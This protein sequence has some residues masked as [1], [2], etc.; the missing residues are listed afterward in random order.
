MLSGPNLLPVQSGFLVYF[1]RTSSSMTSLHFEI[2]DHFMTRDQ[3]VIHKLK[4]R[5][6]IKSYAAL[7]SF[8]CYWSLLLGFILLLS[9]ILL[10]HSILL[11]SRVYFYLLLCT[12]VL[13]NS[14]LDR[15]YRLT[16]VPVVF[17]LWC[18]AS[19]QLPLPGDR[20]STRLNSSH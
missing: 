6:F 13:Q 7:T 9:N 14:V 17:K 8:T 2:H 5:S 10:W 11:Y 16:P 18:L 12:F 3:G 19:L 20:K 1:L 4:P 15:I